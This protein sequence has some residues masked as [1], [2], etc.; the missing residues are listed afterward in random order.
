L[1]VVDKTVSDFV[2]LMGEK[3]NRFHAV[4]SRIVQSQSSNLHPARFLGIEVSQ[5]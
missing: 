5:M 3:T 4:S 1:R 2:I